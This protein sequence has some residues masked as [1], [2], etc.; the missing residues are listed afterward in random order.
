M[1]TILGI[2]IG[3]WSYDKLLKSIENSVENNNYLLLSYVNAY[4]LLQ[5]KIN[6]DFAELLRTNLTL[7]ADGIGVYLASKLLYGRNGLQERINGTDLYTR[8]IQLADKNKHTLYFLG[9]RENAI[10]VLS[11]RLKKLY[12]G[13]NVKGIS[14]KESIDN[15]SLLE[16]LNSSNSD[17]LFVGLGTPLQEEWVVNQGKECNIPV[18]ICVGSGIDYL[19]GT[20]KRAPVFLQKVGFEWL[21]RLIID[22]KRLWKRYLIGIP[23]FILLIIQQLFT[24]RIKK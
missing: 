5:T 23:H 12:P 2:N 13:I 1:P 10:E 4:V 14:G 3:L 19:A 20:Y 6:N 9:G 17:I 21:F 15:E 11:S 24:S 16:K 7:H 22:P 8:I 18:Q